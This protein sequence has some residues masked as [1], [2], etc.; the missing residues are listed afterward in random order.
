MLLPINEKYVFLER[1]LKNKFMKIKKVRAQMAGR[2]ETVKLVKDGLTHE[3]LFP[4]QKME[5]FH[6][7]F[8]HL[9][10]MYVSSPVP[11]K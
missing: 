2:I 1:T 4:Y 10:E 8:W 7:V 9:K 3:D 6:E 5:H 11:R